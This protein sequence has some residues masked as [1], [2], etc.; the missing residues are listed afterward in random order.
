M[1]WH[2]AC[3]TRAPTGE[4]LLDRLSRAWFL[5]AVPSPDLI[6][7]MRRF[8]GL[9][10]A[11]AGSPGERI[12]SIHCQERHTSMPLRIAIAEDDQINRSMFTRLL[13]AL[14]HH[15]VLAV[16]DGHEL[17]DGCKSMEVDLIFADF[18]LPEMDGLAAAEH[19]AGRG[20]P[21]VIISGHVDAEN[22][23]V[24]HEPIEMVIRK[25]AKIDDLRE[26][27]YRASSGEWTRRKPM[28]LG[29]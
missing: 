27:I 8:P 28:L 9:A 21:V 17:V 2:E 29:S 7:A 3:I 15:V 6:R 22:I 4:G 12:Y 1:R 10:V 19:L 23:M 18:H 11:L 14:G 26:A 20:I 13:E 25:P 24:D 16:G 5:N